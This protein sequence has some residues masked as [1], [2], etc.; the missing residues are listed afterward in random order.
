MGS[1]TKKTIRVTMRMAE[2]VFGDGNNTAVIE[3]LPTKAQISKPGGQDM[4]KLSLSI[5]NMAIDRM[6]SLTVLGFKPLK[7]Y[8]NTV[9]VEAGTLGENLGTVFSG[10][11]SSAVP[12]FDNG[13]I[14]SF[15]V[16]AETGS[17]PNKLPDPPM[18]VQGTASVDELMRQFAGEAGYSYQNEG[19]SA[20]VRN[21]VFK[22]SP[23]QK[24]HALARQ[25]GIELLIDDSKFIIMNKGKSRQGGI[26]L[27]DKEHGLLGYPSFT[28]DGIDAKCI[29]D[30]RINIAGLVELQTIVPKASGIWKV[31]KLDHN[32]EAYFPSGGSWHTNFSGI[33]VQDYD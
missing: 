2:A 9:I 11:I 14:V 31:N 30:T 15:K 33:W 12:I 4:N 21:A 20:N 23:I 10:E 17:Y 16:E 5:N 3:G 19:V 13:G 8:K 18:S 32:L 24:A 26:P 7:T 28:N 1:F 25:A 22:G 6:T 27:I 29:F